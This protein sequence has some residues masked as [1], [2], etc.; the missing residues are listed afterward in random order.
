MANCRPSALP[1]EQHCKLHN[2]ES[3]TK[4]DASRYRRLVGKLQYLTVTCPDIVYAVN[5]L[6]QFTS[7]P[8]HSHVVAVE[9]VLR[10][11]KCTPGQGILLRSEGNLELEAYCD[12][13]WGGCPLTRRSSSGYFISLGGSPMPW[14]TKKQNVVAK[15]S[16]EPEYRAMACTV[17]EVLWL[18]WLLK[19]L[20]EQQSKATSLY[21]DNQAA[22]HIATNPVF[23]ERTKHAEMDC[24]FVRERYQS[25]E[26]MPRNVWTR[27]QL[28]YMLT[29]A[30]GKERLKALMGKLGIANLHAP[31]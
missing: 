17:S 6:N 30:L 1:M 14:R 8:K 19:E 31:L 28:A 29:K 7:E 11:L 18:R 4:V 3:E 9:R 10:Y 16:A 12:A 5:I 21:C 23:H 24:Y 15:S 2:D 27:D 22:I 13:D 20:Q 26:I 25:G